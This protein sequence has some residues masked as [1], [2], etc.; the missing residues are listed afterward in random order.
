M[1]NVKIF[2]TAKIIGMDKISFGEYVIID[3]FVLIYAKKEIQIHKFVHI[4]AFSYISSG[5]GRVIMEDFSG[6]SSG[7]KI[8]TATDDYATHGF[9][10]PTISSD[11]R[12]LCVGDVI[13]KKF[14]IIGANSV[15]L[16]GVTIGEGVSVG[17]NSVVTK[18]LEPWGVYIG[19]RRVKNRDR[20]G[21]LERYENF[22]NQ[23][24]NARVG[25]LFK[26]ES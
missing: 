19:N 4:A 7:V 24:L 18:D 15:I 6:I 22:Y 12:N 1:K 10:N 25:N 2:E 5:S 21:V 26:N 11:Y 17:A 16:P 20:D 3:D 8:Y 13:L 14:S 23:P 9:G